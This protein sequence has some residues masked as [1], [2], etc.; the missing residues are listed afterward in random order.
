MTILAVVGEDSDFDR[1]AAGNLTITTS[2]L[3]AN[4]RGTARESIECYVGLVGNLNTTFAKID[5]PSV[6]TSAWVTTRFLAGVGASSAGFMGLGFG[7]ASLRRVGIFGSGTNNKL[8]I[9]KVNSVG[10]VTILATETGTFTAGVLNKYDM[11]L[12]N[13]GAT[14]TVNVYRS[15]SDGSAR[16]LIMTFTGDLTTDA[17]TNLDSVIFQGL[18]ASGT[19]YYS[20]I[21]CATTDT[22][23][24]G[25][26]TI[27]PTANGNTFAWTGGFAD[28]SEVTLNDVTLIS[29]VTAGQ[30]AQLAFNSARLGTPPYIEALVV[31]ARGQS[32]GGVTTFTPTVRVA[33][34]DYFGAGI[35]PGSG[36]KPVQGVFA[37][38]PNTGL[39]FTFSQLTTAGVNYGFRSNV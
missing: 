10:T 8:S 11:Q 21:I 5:L 28:V 13:F 7:K 19:G 37:T 24:M 3:T 20:E 18:N 27:E 4:K 9:G 15:N 16:L 32:G 31:A 12:I 14:G 34:T 6:I 33:A 38:N 39:A 2:I 35:V 17:I 29:S 22:T 23:G 30:I 36:I 26:V 25:L 1:V